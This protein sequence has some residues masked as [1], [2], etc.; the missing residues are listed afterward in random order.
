MNNSR[1]ASGIESNKKRG[2]GK[3]TQTADKPTHGEKYYTNK[4]ICCV[5]VMAAQE[6]GNFAVDTAAVRQARE[7]EGRHEGGRMI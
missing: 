6:R 1:L 4:N 2:K 3:M 5:Q 7:E